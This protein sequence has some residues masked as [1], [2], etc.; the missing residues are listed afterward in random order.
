MANVKKEIAIEVSMADKTT[1]GTES[2]KSRLKALR[3]EMIQLASAGQQNTDRFRQLESEAGELADT[4]AD[5]SQRIK[6]VGSDTRNI[7]A[8]TQAVQGLAA[9]FQ[10]AQ[11]AAGLFGEENED[12]Q[13]AILKVQSAMAIANGVQ[14]I[15]NLLQKESAVSIAANR[16]ALSLYD[17][18]VKG[19][20]I[21]LKAFKVALATTGIGLLAVGIAAAYENWDKLRELLGLPPDNS[22]AIAALEREIAV[23]EA[24]G[25]TTEQINEKRRILIGL[26]AEQLKGQE[27]ENKLNEIKVLNAQEQL[28]AI[29]DQANTTQKLNSVDEASLEILKQKAG[30]YVSVAKSI[31][32]LS[33]GQAILTITSKTSTD[34]VINASKELFQNYQKGIEQQKA[35]A[36]SQA[37]IN[38][39]TIDEAIRVNGLLNEIEKQRIAND[40]QSGN[41]WNDFWLKERATELQALQ[42]GNFEQTQIL[43]N[44]RAAALSLAALALGDTEAY[45]AKEAEINQQYNDLQANQD[46]IYAEKKKQLKAQERDTTIKFAGEAFT[47]ILSLGEAMMGSSEEDARKAFNL[48]KA[49]SIADATVNTFL[50]ATQALRDPKLPTVAKAFAV[51][52]IIASGLAQVRKIAATQ[53]RA[54]GSSGG[55]GGGGTGT[56][57][58]AA[59]QPTEIFAN[60]Q[61]TMLG[62]DGAAMNGGRSVPPTRAYV[63]ERDITQSTRR[64][65]GLEEFAT[66]GG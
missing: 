62:T 16:I 59:S 12:V 37:E 21:S 3:E 4:I 53:F 33:S 6:N 27:K 40:I 18:T 15:A 39:I 50:A 66:I 63:V 25:K 64:V 30:F 54:S 49:A 17:K 24:A 65:R 55:G 1:A 45:R 28:A 32:D 29:T 5:T 34:A 8:F 19:T 58:G 51:G 22:K 48:N 43:E 46:A 47:G 41:E 38:Q 52:G 13:K 31:N 10:I 42:Q 44:R 9:G 36:S 57:A 2:A 11:G 23:M 35:V 56:G 7:E 60:P 26:Q 61:T 20:T 14:Q